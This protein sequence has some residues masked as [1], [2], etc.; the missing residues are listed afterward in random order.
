MA[1]TEIRKGRKFD[2]VLEGARRVF[3]RDGYDGAS[4]DDIAR[5]AGVSKAT[6]YSYFPDKNVLFREI[7]ATECRRQTEAAEA[8]IDMS[9]P[10]EDLLLFAARRIV[11][12]FLSDLGRASF[13][14]V[15]S[16][17]GRFPDLARDFWQNG[18]GLAQDRLA[19]H[20]RRLADAGHLSI[21]NADLAAEQFTH[22][23]KAHISDRLLF[24][25]EDSIAAESVETS[26]RGAV[27]MFMAC[28]GVPR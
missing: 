17:G 26:L 8:E 14:L 13:R 9:A 27:R 24:G 10:V 12:F 18:P 7:C 28:Y 25:M 16:E 15:A 11:G 1:E 22:L 23:S 3:V 4:V 19:H 2:Q 5:E 21:D 6:L 20:L